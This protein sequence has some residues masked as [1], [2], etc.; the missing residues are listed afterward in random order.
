[1]PNEIKKHPIGMGMRGAKKE[2]HY[3]LDHLKNLEKKT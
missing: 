3:L 2:D 1:L